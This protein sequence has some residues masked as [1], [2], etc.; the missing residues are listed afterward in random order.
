MKP[1]GITGIVRYVI[2]SLGYNLRMW[3]ICA[4]SI[5]RAGAGRKPNVR[6]SGAFVRYAI[7]SFTGRSLSYGLPGAFVRL[8]VS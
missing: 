6:G 2:A 8:N 5:V 4:R 7:G 1:E 3:R